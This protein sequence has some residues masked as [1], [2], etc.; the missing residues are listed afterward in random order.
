MVRGYLVGWL[1]GYDSGYDSGSLFSVYVLFSITLPDLGMQKIYQ[2]V[3]AG[4]FG[5][6]MEEQVSF[7]NR[8]AKEVDV[9]VVSMNSHQVMYSVVVHRHRHFHFVIVCLCAIRLTFTML[10]TFISFVICRF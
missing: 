6:P 1:V 8:M 10:W 7:I 2:F 9:V 4:T 5:G 3:L